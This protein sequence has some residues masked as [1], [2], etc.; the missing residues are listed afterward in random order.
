MRRNQLH[1]TAALFPE[2]RFPCTYWTRGWVGLR[3]GLDTIEKKISCSCWESNPDRPAHNLPLYRLSYP[4]LYIVHKRIKYREICGHF[5]GHF[6]QKNATVW[7]LW[8]VQLSCG[9]VDSWGDTLQA[10]R[11]QVG[12]PMRSLNSLNLP[13][14]SSLTMTLGFV[15]PLTEI[16]TRRSFWG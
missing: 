5:H 12:V 1:A 11:S 9:S 7:S 15:Q 10:G 14:P 8:F 4:G 16:S 3:I 13:D 6:T 2:E